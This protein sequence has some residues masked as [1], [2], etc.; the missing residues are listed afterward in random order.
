VDPKYVVTVE[1]NNP[2]YFSHVVVNGLHQPQLFFLQ[3]ALFF[4]KQLG[5]CKINMGLHGNVPINFG[6]FNQPFLQKQF[7]LKHY[8]PLYLIYK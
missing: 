1:L 5:M 6:I 4:N 3:L 2:P 8:L 7:G